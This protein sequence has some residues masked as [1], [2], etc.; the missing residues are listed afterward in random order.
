MLKINFCS[1]ISFR[2]IFERWEMWGGE[3][4]HEIVAVDG[5]FSYRV[6]FTFR[7]QEITDGYIP[8][9]EAC[10]WAATWL[11]TRFKLG[12]FMDRSHH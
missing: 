2:A 4:R 12:H 6:L 1:K 11:I 9:R 3:R 10:S 5:A 7:K 8:Q